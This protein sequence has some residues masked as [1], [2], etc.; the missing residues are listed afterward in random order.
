LIAVG[1]SPAGENSDCS[2]NSAGARGRVMIISPTDVPL[3]VDVPGA[4][5]PGE[6]WPGAGVSGV[7]VA[8]SM[9]E[10]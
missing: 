4:G 9:P 10:R 3:P 1:W 8:S 6:G 7:G 5:W 2:P